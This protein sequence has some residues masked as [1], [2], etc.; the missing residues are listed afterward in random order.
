MMNVFDM[1]TISLLVNAT[2]HLENIGFLKNC[3]VGEN[4]DMHNQK[5]IYSCCYTIRSMAKSYMYHYMRENNQMENP[6]VGK[7]V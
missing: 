1:P 5:N 3:L 2:P 4:G 6:N 7:P